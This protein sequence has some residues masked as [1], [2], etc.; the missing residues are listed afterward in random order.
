MTFWSSFLAGQGRTCCRCWRVLVLEL[1]S[2]VARHSEV[3][4]L[5]DSRRN[6]ARYVLALAKD[7][8]ER[9]AE[10]GDSLD[11]RKSELSNVV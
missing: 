2:D 8:R 9:V 5:V 10:R 4:I 1:V 7:V 11:R 3:G 6:Q